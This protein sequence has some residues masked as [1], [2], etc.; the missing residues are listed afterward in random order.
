MNVEKPP[1]SYCS[2]YVLVHLIWMKI[3]SEKNDQ[4]KN[5]KYCVKG[6]K[7]VY[8]FILRKNAKTKSSFSYLIPI[9][10]VNGIKYKTDGFEKI[11]FHC[12]RFPMSIHDYLN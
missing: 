4:K 10:E 8:H 3:N 5:N 6:K 12:V 9:W 11:Q 7:H 1:P 2:F